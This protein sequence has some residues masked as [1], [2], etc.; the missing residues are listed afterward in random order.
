MNDI[1]AE[2]ASV[3]PRGDERGG[4]GGGGVSCEMV[5]GRCLKEQV[6]IG[7]TNNKNRS[8]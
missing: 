6:A 5:G 3:N 2:P 7:A 8:I 4:G 1:C